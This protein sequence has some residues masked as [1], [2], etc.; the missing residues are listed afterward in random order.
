[1]VTPLTNYC[2]GWQTHSSC[3]QYVG[4]ISDEDRTSFCHKRGLLWLKAVLSVYESV[5]H[6]VFN[7]ATSGAHTPFQTQLPMFSTHADG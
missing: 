3:I 7:A 6:G 1:M 5:L 4:P 2:L